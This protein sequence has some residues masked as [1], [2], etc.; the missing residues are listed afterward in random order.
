MREKEKRREHL[1]LP[2]KKKLLLIEKIPVTVFAWAY[3]LP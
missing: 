1:K 2:A 3:I